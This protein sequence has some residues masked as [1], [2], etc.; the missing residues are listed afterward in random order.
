MHDQDDRPVFV[1]CNIVPE[2]VDPYWHRWGVTRTWR[3]PSER[4]NGKDVT[5]Y[6]EE[7]EQ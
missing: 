1:H 5:A 2:H 3:L 4:G 6:D 7:A